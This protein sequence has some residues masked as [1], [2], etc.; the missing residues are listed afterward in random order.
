MQ[1]PEWLHA[2]IQSLVPEA[3]LIANTETPNTDSPA[4]KSPPKAKQSQSKKAANANAKEEQLAVKRKVEATKTSTIKFQAKTSQLFLQ[5][6]SITLRGVFSPKVGPPKNEK[7]ELLST[8]HDGIF[9]LAVRECEFF[10][11]G[12]KIRLCPLT[13]S[14]VSVEGL[15]S[16]PVD[17]EQLRTTCKPVYV[18]FDRFGLER[19][20]TSTKEHQKNILWNEPVITFMNQFDPELVKEFLTGKIRQQSFTTYVL[21]AKLAHLCS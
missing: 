9:R 12:Q 15:P 3:V 19:F 18:E 7:T 10:S 21:P 14:M 11:L 17:Y 6:N 4:P 16:L 13:I 1:V 20:K 5:G 8:I 2:D